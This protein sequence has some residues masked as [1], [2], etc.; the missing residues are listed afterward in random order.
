[1]A[2]VSENQYEAPVMTRPMT[3]PIAAPPRPAMAKPTTTSRPPRPA[4]RTYV[5]RVFLNPILH[6]F[7]LFYPP[8]RLAT[9][10]SFLGSGRETTCA[11]LGTLR[12]E[13]L[14]D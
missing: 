9:V 4:S 10:L 12:R 11:F 6:H 13:V 8:E 5:L 2:I 7:L 1:M 14:T 3:R